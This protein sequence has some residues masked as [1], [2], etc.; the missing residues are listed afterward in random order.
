MRNF[1]ISHFSDQELKT[2]NV[3]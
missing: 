1:W 2:L 3:F